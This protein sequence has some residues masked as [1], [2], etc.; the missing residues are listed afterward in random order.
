MVTLEEFHALT[1]DQQVAAIED[2]GRNALRQFGVEA[3][4]IKPLVHAENTTYKISS[5]QGDFCLRVSR[6]GYQSS[7]NIQSEIQF[8]VALAEAGFPVPVPYEGRMVRASSPKVPQ[9]RDCVLLRW[10][11]GEFVDGFSVPQSRNIGRLMAELHEFGRNWTMP[12]GFHRQQLH[13]WAFGDHDEPA[14]AAKPEGID[15]A[16]FDLLVQTDKEARDLIKSLPRTPAHFGLMHADLH[17]GNL[18][19]DGDEVRAID[20]DDLGWGFWMYDFAAALAYQIPKPH[21]GDVRAAMLSG[22]AEIC[23]LPPDAEA[24]LSPFLRLR[25]T[26]VACW[27]IRR[28]DNPRMRERAPIIVRQLCEGIRAA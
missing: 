25:L 10:Q 19:F 15:Q 12:E 7:E 13:E 11:E 9:E 22:Y 18:L 24:L 14:L 1:Q 21:Y 23:P 6:P 20:F 28:T 26:G 4:E 5:S 3:T 27:I 2:L 8:L 16:D 17:Q